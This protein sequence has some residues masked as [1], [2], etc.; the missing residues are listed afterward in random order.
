[1]VD[2]HQTE[3]GLPD[4][5][6]W[7]SYS[8]LHMAWRVFLGA[9]AAAMVG[10]L[11]FGLS[12]S[13]QGRPTVLNGFLP[14]LY[15]GIVPLFCAV[16]IAIFGP[17]LRRLYPFSQGL[18]FGALACAAGTLVTAMLS[19]W[20]WIASGPCDPNTYCAGPFDSMIWAAMLLGVP[21]FLTAA[22][23]LGLAIWSVTSKG[24]RKF[25]PGFAI[26]CAFFVTAVVIANT[27]LAR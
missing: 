23:G 26:V 13:G 4:G 17:W 19:L 6:P 1:M 16:L 12:T 9:A 25:W 8:R 24:A 10:T 15:V 18:I 11:F 22:I 2:L 21:M 14:V 20:E 5:H 3:P 7:L 27:L